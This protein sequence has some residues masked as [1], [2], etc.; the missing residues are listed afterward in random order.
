VYDIAAG[1][2]SYLFDL[3]PGRYIAGDFFPSEVERGRV[4]AF[5]ED[6]GDIQFVHA[7]AFDRSTWPVARADVL[8]A[9]G[10]F[11]ILVEDARV[12]DLLRQGTAAT[13]PGG[14]WVFTVMEHHTDPLLLRRTMHDLHGQPW[15][16]TLRS[17]EDLASLAAPFGWRVERIDREPT[18][19]FA[20]GTLVRT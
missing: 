16:V 14:R 5:R 17:A 6:R 18:G 15:H 7:D 1:P 3:P 10:F 4:R 20:V 8:V 11:D 19:F 9:S 2:G 13:A 12:V